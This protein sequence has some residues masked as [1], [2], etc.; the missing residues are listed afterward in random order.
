MY[1]DQLIER[2]EKEPNQSKVIKLGFHEA[3]SWRGDYSE[4][5]FEPKENAIVSEMLTEAK[6]A[7]G[8][9]FEGYK[10]GDFK[11]SNYSPVHLANYSQTG[12]PLS[13]LL[14]DYMLKDEV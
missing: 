8:K 5:A 9:T 11:M 10:G 4:L 2:L 14:I 6:N 7:L 13:S 1:L 12:D 3:H